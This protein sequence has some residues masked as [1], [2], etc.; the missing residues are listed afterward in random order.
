MLRST[1]SCARWQGW[2][3]WRSNE[4]AP[5]SSQIVHCLRS[6]RSPS[7]GS[8]NRRSGYWHLFA[9][10]SRPA[11]EFCPLFSTQIRC[12]K[13]SRVQLVG[14][15]PASGGALP[16]SP[17]L[18][19]SHYHLHPIPSSSSTIFVKS[20][21]WRIES[22]NVAAGAG[23][24]PLTRPRRLAALQRVLPKP[25]VPACVLVS[26]PL[27]SAFT[28]CWCS[29]RACGWAQQR[30]RWCHTA[31]SA[32]LGWA[33]P[34]CV[35]ATASMWLPSLFMAHPALS[36]Y[37]LRLQAAPPAVE[38]SP[39]RSAV[40]ASAAGGV[41]EAVPVRFSLARQVEL[42]QHHVLVGNH[43]ALGNWAVGDAPQMTWGEGHEWHAEIAL[44]PGTALEFKVGG[45]PAFVP[46]VRAWVSRGLC[47]LS[48]IWDHCLSASCKQNARLSCVLHAARTG[49]GT[50][51]R[52]MLAHEAYCLPWLC[53]F[54]QLP[55]LY[56][57][58]GGRQTDELAAARARLRSS[59][60]LPQCVQVGKGGEAW[61]GGHNHVLNVPSS[62][63]AR[64]AV[65]VD[66]GA[67][68]LVTADPLHAADKG[69]A[70]P[71]AAE[72]EEPAAAPLPTEAA[73]AP[74]A[75]APHGWSNGNGASPAAAPSSSTSWDEVGGQAGLRAACGAGAAAYPRLGCCVRSSLR[76]K[77]S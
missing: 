47:V 3:S 58:P 42:G 15:P 35:G 13:L 48:G 49:S 33:A 9:R 30:Q 45:P 62:G 46:C 32:R 61:E 70:G 44:P 73:A 7:T 29:Q 17:T 76:I 26:I 57:S 25:A 1:G 27:M 51:F 72:P 38:R 75:A 67:D 37:A 22:S 40:R 50:S 21:V 6:Y 64:M 36:L 23:L 4:T 60:L 14:V 43:P 16:S 11:S 20:V 39:A 8:L 59:P 12:S 2:E 10:A 41:P 54:A 55:V 71:A 5:R 56:R 28:G 69:L 53:A 18:V 77:C 66:W 52:L 74:A 34:C 68:M 31:V 19:S 65:V 63:I 24:R